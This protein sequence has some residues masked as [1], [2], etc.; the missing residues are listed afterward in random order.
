MWT[1]LL[2]VSCLL[3]TVLAE[4]TDSF[5]RPRASLLEY[6]DNYLDPQT[7]LRRRLCTLHPRGRER[8]DSD[9]FVAAVNRCGQGGIIR[10][11]D[12]N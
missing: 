10:L 2:A 11:P 1:K 12:S 8:D 6:E 5:I 4:A 3:T 7:N 9:N